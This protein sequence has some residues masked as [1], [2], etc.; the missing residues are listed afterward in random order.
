MNI[1]CTFRTFM[2]MAMVHQ[3]L[4]GKVDKIKTTVFPDPRY[5]GYSLTVLG[6]MNLRDILTVSSSDGSGTSQVA[7]LFRH[8]YLASIP[9]TW[10]SSST[11]C[12]LMLTSEA[13]NDNICS[14]SFCPIVTKSLGMVP[15][16]YACFSPVL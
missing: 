1:P 3:Y 13:T 9:F 8:I 11:A 10:R 14:S 6:K 4:S 7:K 16:I 5:S 15:N 2:Y 12:L